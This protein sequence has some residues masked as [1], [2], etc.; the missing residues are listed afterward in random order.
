MPTPAY[1]W[2]GDINNAGMEVVV[3]GWIDQTETSMTLARSET[4]RRVKRAI[5]ASG[6]TFPNVTYTIEGTSL[7]NQPNAVEP[8]SLHPARPR[9]D[10]K[11]ATVIAQAEGSLERMIDTEREIGIGEDLLRND[12]AKE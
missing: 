10:V 5:L 9:D 1:A 3:V 8:K 12:A 11:I 2:L 6:V 7:G 4:L